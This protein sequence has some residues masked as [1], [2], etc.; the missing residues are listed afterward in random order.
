MTGLPEFEANEEPRIFVKIIQ[1]ETDE[2]MTVE[3]VT[4]NS[5]KLQVEPGLVLVS[6][7]AGSLDSETVYLGF[8]EVVN[9][10]T[11]QTRTLDV[12]M[13]SYD[14][15]VTIRNKGSLRS[16]FGLLVDMFPPQKAR[17]QTATQRIPVT[18]KGFGDR[19]IAKAFTESALVK[20]K[21]FVVIETG[22]EYLEMREQR[23][24]WQKEGRFDPESFVDYSKAIKPKF[25]VRGSI[26]ET[27]RSK[28]IG[29]DTSRGAI[30]T[31]EIDLEIV[32]IETGEV[33][34]R[35]N[36]S[37]EDVDVRDIV[38]EVLD[39]AL[40][41]P[42]APGSDAVGP[43]P[44]PK[45]KTEIEPE[46]ETETKTEPQT[47][48]E[49]RPEIEEVKACNVAG[50]IACGNQFNLQA[51]ID[52]CPNVATSCPASAPPNSEC[53]ATDATCSN[54]CFDQAD[55]HLDLCLKDNNCTQ[56]EVQ[57]AGAGAQ[58]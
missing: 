37:G 22:T 58:R 57:A 8:G 48:L 50:F 6:V 30:R 27:E 33:V 9:I 39:R 21:K 38:E 45:A 4:G 1:P 53:V 52:A 54:Q 51:C 25:I 7:V 11:G 29:T 26:K 35:T 17:A 32:D 19:P 20:N 31:T 15:Q 16:P 46:M 44:D 49:T 10:Q 14:Q 5:F 43:K 56:A 36:G 13:R 47:K 41:E 34:A 23:I 24:Q 28:Y 2:I 3:E 18:V 40:D 12:L 55:S 42:G